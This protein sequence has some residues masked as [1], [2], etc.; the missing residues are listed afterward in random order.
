MCFSINTQNIY[1]MGTYI[2]I[3]YIIQYYRIINLIN[4]LMRTRRNRSKKGGWTAV[5]PSWNGGNGANH[6]ALS[7]TGVQVGGIQPAVSEMWGPGMHQ[8][9]RLYKGGKGGSK[10]SHKSKSSRSRSQRG[11]FIFGGF[12]QDLSI[13]WDNLKIGAQNFYRGFMGT[14]QLNSASPWVQPAL[15]SKIP[16]STTKFINPSAIRAAA[17]A[18]VN[19]I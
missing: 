3:I 13:G 1:N 16:A 7:K 17:S 8:A 11:G 18:R 2:Y 4:L 6:F 15:N 12:P 9:N 19:Q 5:G 10:R 14:N